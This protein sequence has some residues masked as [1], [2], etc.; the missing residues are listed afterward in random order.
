MDFLKVSGGVWEK[1]KERENSRGVVRLS[2]RNSLP[3]KFAY[4]TCLASVLYFL[5]IENCSTIIF[6]VL[7]STK[8]F[9]VEYNDSTSPLLH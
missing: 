2:P 5:R 4:V 1:K 3:F 7:T 6:H 9:V 8:Y